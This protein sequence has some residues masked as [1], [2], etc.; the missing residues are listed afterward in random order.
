MYQEY[1]AH[2]VSRDLADRPYVNF[3]D[4]LWWLIYRDTD[5]SNSDTADSFDISKVDIDKV[6]SEVADIDR[7]KNG[8]NNE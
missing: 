1:L 6:V 4:Y 7:P 3:N 5:S 8:F 2:S